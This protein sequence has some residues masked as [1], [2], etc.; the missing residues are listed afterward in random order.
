MITIVDGIEPT[1]DEQLQQAC[2]NKLLKNKHKGNSWINDELNITLQYLH[3]KLTEEF[4]EVQLRYYHN[5]DMDTISNELCD[6]INISSM[7]YRRY[8][9]CIWKCPNPNHNFVYFSYDVDKIDKINKE[10]N[11]K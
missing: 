11:T 9:R 3:Q 1:I 7:L 10:V 6:I 2:Y 4:S 8:R 5:E